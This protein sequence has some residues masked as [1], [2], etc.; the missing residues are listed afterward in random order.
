MPAN[1]EQMSTNANVEEPT[2][3]MCTYINEMDKSIN[4]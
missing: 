2:K 1:D 3:N 4:S